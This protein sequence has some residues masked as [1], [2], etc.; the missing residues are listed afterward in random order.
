MNKRNK[1]RI[2]FYALVFFALCIVFG[3]AIVYQAKEKS[4]LSK[5]IQTLVDKLNA[6]ISEAKE[7]LQNVDN[8]EFIKK[9][10]REKLK[11]VEK[12]EVIVKYKDVD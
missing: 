6:E 8:E 2:R 12:D 3:K 9:V 1:A 10:A 11:M 4:R 7:S 5:K